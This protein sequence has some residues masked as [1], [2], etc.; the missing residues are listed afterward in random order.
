MPGKYENPISVREAID[1]INQRDFLLPSIQRKF[2][3]S[4]HQICVLFD[5]LMRGYPINSFM[6][7][8]VKNSSIKNNYKFYEFLKSYCQ[9][10]DEENPHQ[11]TSASYKDFKAVIDG[12]Q[13][14]TSLYIGLCGTYAYKNTR[15]HWPSAKDDKV[16][17]PRKLYLNLKEALVS[18]DDEALMRYDFKFLTDH[19]YAHSENH[20]H[21]FCL[22]D[23]LKFPDCQS[24]DDALFEVVLPELERRGLIDCT[25]ARET[26]LELYD[27]I[28]VQPVI[29]YFCEGSQKIDY[30][31]DVFIRTNSGGTKLEFSDLL[32]SIV[33]AQWDGD[34]RKEIDD[35][36][37]QIHQN[38]EMGFFIERDWLLK[39]CLMLTGADV[40]FKV[41][42]F[43]NEQ[44]VRIQKEWEAIKDCV[45][46]AFRLIRRFG[47]TPPSL[48]SKN[49]VL[50]ICYYLF[51]KQNNG[52]AL[53]KEINN[54]SK[55][56]DQ[57]KTI[58][59][60]FYMAMLKGVFGGQ[61]DTI[62]SSMRDILD[63]NISK[64]RFPLDAIIDRY[65]GTNKDL[66]FDEAAI[67]KLLET[68]HGEGRCR[69]LLHLLFPEMNATEVFHIDHLHPLSQFSI[70]SL[71]GHEFLFKDDNL[72]NFYSDRTHW[73]TV[74]N[75][76]LLNHSQ[77]HSKNDM[78][79]KDWLN[80]KDVHVTARSLLIEDVDLDF[81][82][83]KD[84]YHARRAALKSRLMSRVYMA[85]QINPESIADADDDDEESLEQQEF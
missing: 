59:Q 17:P 46:S 72:K 7:W 32:M 12:Q 1:L 77:N 64:D 45:L 31:L 55:L 56:S 16:L 40:R 22:H 28:R 73:N 26:L 10:F 67:D 18:E 57:R 11:P 8:E 25:F 83:F 37:K 24:R 50:P 3:W 58:S 54:L 29:H 19:Q 34:F 36:L 9:R 27:V 5:S 20:S 6:L 13:R 71:K 84:F 38:A 53:Y 23:L 65:K 42:N 85:A 47:I 81:E 60:W 52:V 44:V 33:V 21:W 62:I 70:K 79:L 2:V 49:A 61:A 15:V 30:V 41:G 39:A 4:S 43:K 74:P 51:Q 68:E 35:L 66:R 75:L 48:T 78:P 63:C 80:D 76:H 14:L 82:S 69:A